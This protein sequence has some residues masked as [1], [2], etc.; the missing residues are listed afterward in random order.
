MFA[1]RSDFFALSSKL[2][3]GLKYQ[4]N[5][6][7]NVNLT[8]TPK[9][10]IWIP[11]PEQRHQQVPNIKALYSFSTKFRNNASLL[12]GLRANTMRRTS[13]QRPIRFRA[14]KVF[15]P[16]PELANLSIPLNKNRAR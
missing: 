6:V 13:H 7:D 8:T 4:R 16:L 11:L 1:I 5:T 2:A 9:N 14:T 12:V 10:D 3:T 15:R